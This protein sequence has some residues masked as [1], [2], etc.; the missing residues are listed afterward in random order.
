MKYELPQL[1][2]PSD[3]LEPVISKRTIEFHYGKHEQ[4]YI[5][6][7]NNLIQGTKYEEIPIETII[8]EADGALFNNASQ[9]WNHIFYFFTFTPDG[10]K[11]PKGKLAEAIKEK[12]GTIEEFKK[13]FV[14]AG[15][16]LFGSGWVW[17]V[18]NK[19]GKLDIVKESN[20]GNPMTKGFI[21]LLTFDVWEHAYYLDYQNRRADQ[22]HDLWKIVDWE[23]V[24]KRFI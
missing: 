13:A 19:E 9:A 11:E 23:V 20:A 5:N 1:P 14:D 7:L 12:W 2:Y 3:A 18:K 15:T 22:L 16:S 8:K 21:P 4:G 10:G 24:E 6:N 17:L